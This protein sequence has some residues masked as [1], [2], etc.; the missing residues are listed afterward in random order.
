MFGCYEALSGGELSEALE[1]FTG[2]VSE[3][4]DLQTEPFLTDEA[5]REKFY[6]WLVG[7]MDNNGVMC[8]AINVSYCSLNDTESV[9][10]V[11]SR[12]EC[13]WSNSQSAFIVHLCSCIY[14]STEMLKL[15]I[16]A[17]ICCT[18]QL[19]FAP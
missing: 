18:V 1:D 16:I 8:A 12:S 6:D 2:G 11:F 13:I 5:Q 14:V 19:I 9:C 4:R 3:T 15:E 17:L 7:I 10:T